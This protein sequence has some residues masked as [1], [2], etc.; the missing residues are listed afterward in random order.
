MISLTRETH[1]ALLAYAQEGVPEEVC[2]VLGGH[3][4]SDTHIESIY[5]IPNVATN[6]HVEYVIDP[7]A[8]LDA[9][10]E[11]ESTGREVVGFYHSHPRGPE[12]PSETDAERAT[13][14][15][16][17]YL[18]VALDGQPSISTWRWT[19]ER[20]ETGVLDIIS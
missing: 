3:R 5:R 6:P 2:G 20:F 15:G 16:F 12:E 4:E 9:M 19:G 18:I 17:Y 14:P 1:E 11:I 13:W 10:E 8:Q 7:E